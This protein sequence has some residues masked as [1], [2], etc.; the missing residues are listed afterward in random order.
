MHFGKRLAVR[1]VDTNQRFAGSQLCVLQGAFPGGTATGLAITL[2]YSVVPINLCAGRGGGK[3]KEATS[4]SRER[5]RGRVNA[6]VCGE[7]G[8]L[9]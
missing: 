4:A 6:K 7:D 2:I 1:T 3:G 8:M 5:S 9:R